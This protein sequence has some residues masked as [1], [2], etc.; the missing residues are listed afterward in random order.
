MQDELEPYL[1]VTK[2]LYKDMLRCAI[3]TLPSHTGH[4]LA[5]MRRRLCIG[6][7]LPLVLLSSWRA[8]C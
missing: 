7:I 1:E 3:H 8:I 2:K 6:R 4:S 5:A